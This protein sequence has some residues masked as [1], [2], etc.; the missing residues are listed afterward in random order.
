MV[1]AVFLYNSVYKYRWPLDLDQGHSLSFNLLWQER[2]IGLG[3][4]ERETLCFPYLW[5]QEKAGRLSL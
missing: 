5:I 3:H 4:R 2:L 1:T